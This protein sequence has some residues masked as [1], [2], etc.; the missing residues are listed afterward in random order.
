[1]NP[2]LSVAKNIGALTAVN[3]LARALNFVIVAVVVRTA[4]AEGLGGYA[5][6][7]AISGFA[8]IAADLGLSPRLI[9][10][11]AAHPS[12]TEEEYARSLGIKMLISP[13]IAAI[14]VLLFF[15]LPY[16]D[17]ILDLTL[18]FSFSW[19]I[20]SYCRLSHSVFRSR[21]RM[22]LEALSVLVQTVIFMTG[23][24][25]LLFLGLPIVTLGW[26]AILA[27][28]IQL[29]VSLT[30][31]KKFIPIRIEYPPRW[32]TAR[33]AAPYATTGIAQMTLAQSAIIILS[34]V[35]SQTLVGE[36]TAISRILILA[37]VFPVFVNLA[38]V[39]A[40]SR[41]FQRDAAE[42]FK[43]LATASTCI[44]LI[45]PSAGIV[46]VLSSARQILH[47]A[48]GSDLIELF[49]YLQ[50]G[51]TYLVFQFLN[52]SL[53]M[54][55]TSA[56]RQGARAKATALG[57]VARILFTFAL[58]PSFEIMGAIAALILSECV[59]TIA[60]GRRARDLID[61]NALAK[62]AGWVAG[63]AALAVAFHLNLAA[64]GHTQSAIV[65]PLL[66]YCALLG[67]SREPQKMVAIV[68]SRQ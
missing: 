16:D 61:S 39:P 44:M 31:V 28:T 34:V 15:I 40:F 55:L 68:R 62:T 46:L 6:A 4:G 43:R 22:E 38:V 67:L 42:R 63:G 35:A 64:A 56:G 57:C 19:I 20:R 50:P 18:L 11:A 48:Y 36:F 45:F 7:M 1:M 30:L 33:K 2:I 27:S 5:T 9:R 26:A 24:L 25:L 52:G 37:T 53:G 41:I 23:A 29:F 60:L 17:W 10:E 54:A 13:A 32:S 3:L 66:V 47:Y 58:A 59:L 21:E 65:A 49:P 12:S 14:A 8:V 51:T